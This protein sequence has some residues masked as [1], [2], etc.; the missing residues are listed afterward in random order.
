MFSIKYDTIYRIMKGRFVPVE[1]CFHA[2]NVHD[3]MRSCI[4]CL[5][6]ADLVE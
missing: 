6:I 2:D 4:E 3:D 1:A 5:L